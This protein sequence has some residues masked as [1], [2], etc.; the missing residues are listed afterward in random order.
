MS[1]IAGR[2]VTETFASD[3]GRRVTACVPSAPPE[4]VV[5]AGDGQLI[6]PWGGIFEAADLPLTMIVG[7]HREND[8]TLRLH[9]YSPGES[10]ATFTFDA[11]RFGG[12]GGRTRCAMQAPTFS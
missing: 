2:L 9:E 5:F 3:G 4:A 7:A 10:T 8:E 12:R 6:A 1:P 11:A